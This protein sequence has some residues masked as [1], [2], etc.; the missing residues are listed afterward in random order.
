MSTTSVSTTYE[1]F[2]IN[3]PGAEVRAIVH[4]SGERT[5]H[6]SGQQYR[7]WVRACEHHLPQIGEAANKLLEVLGETVEA[8]PTIENVVQAAAKYGSRIRT[9]VYQATGNGRTVILTRAD[10]TRTIGTPKYI[11]QNLDRWMEQYP[12]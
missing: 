4:L 3:K 9:V 6:L 12:V 1:G 11:I 8:A 5:I 10:G 2:S 7:A